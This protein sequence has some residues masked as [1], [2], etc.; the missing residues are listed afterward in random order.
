VELTPYGMKCPLASARGHFSFSGQ[1][2]TFAGDDVLR[3]RHLF[4][5]HGTPGLFR[6]LQVRRAETGYAS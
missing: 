4:E 1:C 3:G 6:D 5:T 2:L